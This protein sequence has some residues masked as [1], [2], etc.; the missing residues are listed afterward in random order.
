[1]KAVRRLALA[2]LTLPALLLTFLAVSAAP[3]L[4]AP[5]WGIEMTHANAYG[6]QAASCP[7]GHESLPGEPVCGVDPYTG[8]GT[9]FS[10]ESGFNSYTIKV[11]NT[12][13]ATLAAGDTLAC[14]AG[15]W[16]RDEST[17]EYRWLRNGAK[18]AG[19]EGHEYTL[20]AEDEG[21]A[22]QCQVQGINASFTTSAATPAVVA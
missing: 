3:A 2:S 21:K 16:I 9:T 5:S 11:K 14:Q 4:A 17:F 12:A 19:A 22:I 18:I 1:M 13:P 15:S 10:R 7:G 6:A 8:S 20:T